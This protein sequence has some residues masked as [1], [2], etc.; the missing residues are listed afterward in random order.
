[1][2][3]LPNVDHTAKVTIQ[4]SDPNEHNYEN[5][6]HFGWSGGETATDAD[7]LALATFVYTTYL[8]QLISQEPG[9]YGLINQDLTLEKVTAIDLSSADG[10][11]GEK[12]AAQA[13]AGTNQLAPSVSCVVS[14]TGGPRYRGGHPRTYIPGIDSYFF[15]AD[16]GFLSAAYDQVGVWASQINESVGEVD[17]P[18]ITGVYQCFINYFTG[19]AVITNPI[20]G[21]ARNVPKQNAVPPVHA[22]TGFTVSSKQ[23]TQRRR[24]RPSPVTA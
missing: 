1:M 7:M 3:P 5:I 10:A 23:R 16:G 20:T 6:L 2:P 4:L 9:G 21:R 15:S 14:W 19:F 17:Y 22:I 24:L 11:S 8:D 12:S 13:G 18:V